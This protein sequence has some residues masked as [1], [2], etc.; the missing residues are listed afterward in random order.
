MAAIGKNKKICI[1]F[2]GI[3]Y[4]SSAG[5]RVVLMSGKKL[6]AAGG[7][8][9]LINMPQKIFQVFKMS[10]FDKILKIFGTFDESKQ[11]FN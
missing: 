6:T 8:L 5:L 2:D 11:I 4:I 9:A 1:S 3:D 10:G 7:I